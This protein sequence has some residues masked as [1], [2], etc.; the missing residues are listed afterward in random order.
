MSE[1]AVV[2][3]DPGNKRWAQLVENDQ[4][5]HELIRL[6]VER[7]DLPSELNYRLIPSETGD[8]LKDKETLSRA[9]VDAGDELRLMLLRDVLFRKLREKLYERVIEYVRDAL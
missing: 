5:I 7:L 3:F 2:I 1:I 4:P 9:G 6:L 8:A